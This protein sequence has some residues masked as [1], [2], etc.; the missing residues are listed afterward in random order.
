MSEKPVRNGMISICCEG[1]DH[2]PHVCDEAPCFCDFNGTL[3]SLASLRQRS[4]QA[5]VRSA[6]LHQ[7]K[8]S[9]V[10]FGLPARSRA[11]I[12]RARVELNISDWR[13]CRALLRHRSVQCTRG[14][15]SAGQSGI[16][17][18]TSQTPEAGPSDRPFFRLSPSRPGRRQTGIAW[19]KEHPPARDAAG[20]QR[21][22]A[23]PRR[24]PSRFRGC[25]RLT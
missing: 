5:K 4:S 22:R 20:S 24:S 21:K 8:L 2:P 23:A 10:M 7:P 9:S 1:P 18:E 6:G 3:Y 15:A 14:A 12:D 13:A 17:A 19:T 11:G 16:I 25:E